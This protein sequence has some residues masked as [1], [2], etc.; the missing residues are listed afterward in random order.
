MMSIRFDP[1]MSFREVRRLLGELSD[2]ANK[3]HVAHL[4]WLEGEAEGQYLTYLWDPL[5]ERFGHNIDKEPI[6]TQIVSNLITD[7]AMEVRLVKPQRLERR[8]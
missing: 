2:P 6:D 1:G 3:D 4:T 8:A 5:A 7:I